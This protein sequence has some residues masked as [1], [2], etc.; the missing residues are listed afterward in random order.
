M[1]LYPSN[2]W[3]IYFVLFV[4]ICFFEVNLEEKG[5]SEPIDEF[6]SH[7]KGTVKKLSPQSDWYVIVPDYNPE[8]R[9]LPTDLPDAYMI[10]G[11]R[12]VFSGKVGEIPPNA[13]LVGTPLELT[14]IE[15]LE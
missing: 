2:R 14:K 12:V 1:A 10:N 5:L 15:T 9:F 8:L 11:L 4:L 13:R 6:V 7:A 3:K